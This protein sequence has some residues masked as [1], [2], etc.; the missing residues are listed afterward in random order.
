MGGWRDAGLGIGAGSTCC[1]ADRMSEPC[2]RI[3][4]PVESPSVIPAKAGIQYLGLDSGSPFHCARNDGRT[5]WLVSVP[6]QRIPM[7]TAD[8]TTVI[9]AKAGIQCLG[10]DSGSPLHCARNDG[11]RGAG[12]RSLLAYSHARRTDPPSFPRKRE[13]NT[14]AWIPGLRCTAPGMT[15]QRGAGI[16]SLSAY[17]HARRTDP[18]SFP[19]KRESNTSAWIPGLRFIAP[20]MTGERGG[21]YPFLT[22]VFPCAPQT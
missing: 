10:L 16:R 14:S 20:G 6:Y 4:T 19:R 2:Q 18:P 15:G 11:Q 13:S 7:R 1:H 9:P 5:G 22:S 17:S 12:I 8:Q 21:W 3:P